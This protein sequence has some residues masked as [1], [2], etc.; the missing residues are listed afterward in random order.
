MNASEPGDGTLSAVDQVELARLVTELTWR[1]DHGKA[2]TAHELFADQGE[3][4]LGPESIF[5]GVGQIRQWGRHLIED[6]PY[7]GIRHV[8]TN[9]RFVADGDGA[10]IGTTL[11]TAYVRREDGPAAT[12]PFAI[13]EDHDRFVRT[14]QGWRFLSRRWELLFSAAES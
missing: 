8:C 9:M 4:I 12:V 5:K 10:A 3:L 6:D 11:V 2:D 13:G 7:P 14:E 1:I